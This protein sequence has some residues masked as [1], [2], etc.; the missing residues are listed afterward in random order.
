VSDVIV[1]VLHS[2][3]ATAISTQDGNV[4]EVVIGDNAAVGE[5]VGGT[6]VEVEMTQGPQ[7]P[8]NIK[9]QPDNPNFT[10]PGLWIQTGLGDT[11]ED[12]TFWV[13]DGT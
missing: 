10:I 3:Q 8:G 2:E 9:I 5:A 13:E 1:E 6:L 12:V 4:I 11:G 7:G